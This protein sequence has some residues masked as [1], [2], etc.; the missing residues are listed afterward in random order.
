MLIDGTDIDNNN[1]MQIAAGVAIVRLNAI[2]TAPDRLGEAF[3]M[4]IS[5]T[6]TCHPS[7]P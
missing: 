4:A 5:L 1:A 3:A 6:S 2:L 7:R